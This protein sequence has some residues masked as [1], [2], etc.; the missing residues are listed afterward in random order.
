MDLTDA[1]WALLR[2]FLQPKGRADGR[3][4]PGRAARQV[5]NAVLWIPRTGAAWSDLPDHYPPYQTCLRRF[6]PWHRNGQ[7]QR[8][9]KRVAED[10]RDRGKLDLSQAFI[11]G[12]FSKAKK[13]APL[14]ALIAAEKAAASRRSQ[15]AMAFLSPCTWP[16]LEGM[17]AGLSKSPSN[18]VSCRRRR[19]D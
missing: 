13:W 5:L 19:D 15:T 6:Q 1:Q 12:T 3:G 7:F 9:L 17:R 10:L 4:G 11:G 18:S 16:A 2:L 14:C 8:I